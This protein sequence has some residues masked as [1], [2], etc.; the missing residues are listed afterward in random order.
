MNDRT[1]TEEANSPTNGN[2]HGKAKKAIDV[3][4]ILPE[5]KPE[6]SGVLQEINGEKESQ[7]EITRM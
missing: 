3:S 1:T 4:T 7:V 2:N 5:D 6:I